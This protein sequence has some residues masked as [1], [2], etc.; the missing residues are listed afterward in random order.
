MGVPLF[1]MIRVIPAN[2]SQAL[3]GIETLEWV[4][5][6]IEVMEGKMED[7][8]V[9]PQAVVPLMEALLVVI[10]VA[11]HILFLGEILVIMGQEVV[12]TLEVQVEVEVMVPVVE[13]ALPLLPLLQI[14]PIATTCDS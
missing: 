12:D 9:V 8:F 13:G 11:L 3:V 5:F 7:R 2:I 4:E 10:E 1:V 14:M 6:L